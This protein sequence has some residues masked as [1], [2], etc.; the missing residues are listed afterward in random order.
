MSLLDEAIKA[1]EN[2][3]SPYSKFR[4]GAAVKTKDGNVFLGCNIE[5]VSYGLTMC[6]ER[7]ALYK[8]ISSGYKK[9][10]LI[11]IA[12]V[13]DGTKI[14]S[15]CGACRQVMLEL[16]NENSLIILG[17][18][19]KEIKEFKLSELLPYSF[20]EILWNQDL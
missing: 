3:Y 16:M 20:K 13:S 15:P 1:L 18:L 14:I 4:V 5:N 7:I 11:E 12:I 9:D 8:A 2:S 6:A 10:D 19:N 17:N